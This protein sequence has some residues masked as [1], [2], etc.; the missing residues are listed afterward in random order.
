MTSDSLA[1][2]IKSRTAGAHR[3]VEGLLDVDAPGFDADAWRA[4]LG[5][6]HRVVAPLEAQLTALPALRAW[7]PDWDARRRAHLLA[8]DLEALG[9]EPPPALPVARF[10]SLGAA[11]GAAYVLEGSTLGGRV[12]LAR[13]TPRM[14]PLLALS[15]RYHRRPD[16][17]VAW[18]TFL[19]RLNAFGAEH[20]TRHAA[21]V[22]AA[23]ETFTTFESSFEQMPQ[24]A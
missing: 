4:M 22:L 24:R 23:N 12:I 11:L 18:R 6:L 9:V 2:H 7:L 8:A 17:G 19:Q 1:Q 20:P 15:D 14:G 10:D 5:A 3:R 16:A 13:L 21:C